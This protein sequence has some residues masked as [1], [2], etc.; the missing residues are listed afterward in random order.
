MRLY[1]PTEPLRKESKCFSR[2]KNMS[3]VF[4]VSHN[5]MDECSSASRS[6]DVLPNSPTCKKKMFTDRC[7]SQEKQRHSQDSSKP[8]AFFLLLLFNIFLFTLATR[9]IS[10][11][12]VRLRLL[13]KTKSLFFVISRYFYIPTIYA[14]ASQSISS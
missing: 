14:E 11:S 13:F 3:L 2:I 10:L 12:S 9:S 5:Y 4:D 1:V 6:A 7:P 8:T